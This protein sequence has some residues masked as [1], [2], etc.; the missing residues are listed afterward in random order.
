[1]RI[2]ELDN[3]QLPTLNSQ[4][5]LMSRLDERAKGKMA[6]LE[7]RVAKLADMLEDSRRARDSLEHQLDEAEKREM[8]NSRKAAG[9]NRSAAEDLDRLRLE[10]ERHQRD[11]AKYFATVE[12][13]KTALQQQVDKLE[14]AKREALDR[15]SALE[16]SL[17]D[18]TEMRDALQEELG[19]V[20]DAFGREV[21]EGDV[22]RAEYKY[23]F[24]TQFSFVM[25]SFLTPVFCF[26]VLFSLPLAM[27]PKC[28]GAQ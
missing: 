1:M 24:L 14:G 3:E 18:F 13:E 21:E 12:S 26:F 28:Y 6:E 22:A 7:D 19:I 25:S 17:E 8:E 4:I 5:E 10:L 2:E 15:I 20:Q 16:K 23:V 27:A 11:H 9:E